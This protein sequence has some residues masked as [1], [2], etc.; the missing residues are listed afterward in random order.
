MR[1]T[2]VSDLTPG[3]V[4]G[5][6]IRNER[7]D[8]LLARGVVLSQTMIESL[9]LHGFY[10]VYV[11]DGVADDVEVQD[12]LSERVRVG[13]YK[14]VQELFSVVQAALPPGN[15][16]RRSADVKEVLRCVE[17]HVDSLCYDVEQIIDEVAGAATMSGVVSL[18]SHD[19]YTF[20]HSIDVAVAGVV[21]GQ[22]LSLRMDH[23]RQLALGCLCHDIGKVA[24]PIDVLSKPGRLSPEEYEL[25][26]THVQVGYE[27]SRQIM[28][29]DAVF[30]RQIIWQHHEHQNGAGYPR[31]L[32]GTNGFTSQMSAWRGSRSILPLAEIA[33]VADV[34]SA[35][36]SDR[37]Y[38]RALGPSAVAATLRGMAGTHLNSQLVDCFLSILPRH[39]VG[40]EVEIATGPLTQWRGIVVEIDA[41]DAHRLRVRILFDPRGRS[42]S[43]FEIECRTGGDNNLHPVDT[44]FKP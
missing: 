44:D 23:L 31:G 4:L 38:R 27:T 30:A 22:R 28:P 36:A 10:A 33:A 13:T 42:V 34:Y 25:V 1:K 7:G 14:H 9:R 17:P 12:L 26:K 20:E 15:G 40:A 39:A 19:S 3:A 21:L 35:L 43:P 18:K 5:K 37:P 24:V 32:R 16:R 29:D 41:E 11:M 6:T 2:Y 8:V